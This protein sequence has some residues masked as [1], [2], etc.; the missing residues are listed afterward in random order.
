VPWARLGRQEVDS[1]KAPVRHCASEV[2]AVPQEPWS[3]TSGAQLREVPGR[4]RPLPS[5]VRAPSS[6]DP[7]QL[8]G[9]H[10]LPAT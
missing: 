5:Q 9:E 3:Q 8:T 7:L 10:S 4:Q 2:Q 1:Q 6:I